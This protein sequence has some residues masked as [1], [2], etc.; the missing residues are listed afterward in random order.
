MTH[1]TNQ[2]VDQHIHVRRYSVA[3][4][5][6]AGAREQPMSLELLAPCGKVKR[7][8]ECEEEV[9]VVT[10]SD[11]GCSVDSS[12]GGGDSG[13]GGRGGACFLGRSIIRARSSSCFGRV[14]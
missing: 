7:D 8:A 12:A 11:G 3:S 6:P 1:R 13:G 9:N 4:G 14:R 10:A 2:P 5:V